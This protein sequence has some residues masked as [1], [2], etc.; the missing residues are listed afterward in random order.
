MK[1]ETLT[2]VKKN[3][4]EEISLISKAISK[5]RDEIEENPYILEAKKVLKV[6]GYRSA[7]G[8]YWNALVDDLRNKIIHRSLDLFNKEMTFNQ[9]IKNYEDFQ[10]C[11][12]D[13]DLIEGAYKIGVI[14]WE[15]RKILH[16]AREIRHI[17]DGHPRSSDPSPIKVLDM[18]NDCNKYVLSQEFPPK[19]I[20]IDSYITTMDSKDYDNN[21]I[22]VE[23]A[24]SDLPAV[25]KKELINKF[26]AI[27]TDE[28]TSTILRANIE[29]CLPILWSVLPKEDRSQIGH[30]FNT[31]ITSG[32]KK[33]IK[34]GTEFLCLIN[35]LR[36]AANSARK[37]IFEPVLKR[38]EGN[39][40]QWHEEG[41]TVRELER[42]GSNI[43][44]ELIHRYVSAL[45]LTYVGYKGL[46]IQCARTDFYSNSAAPVI[47]KL[48]DKL[49]NRA[50]QEFFNNIKNN[51][52]LKSRIINSGQL[53]RLRNLA[54]IILDRPGLQKDVQE[55]LE[56]LVDESKTD[57]FLGELFFEPL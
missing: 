5:V 50:A 56:F 51:K 27:Y 34:R 32:N 12:T 46:S 52:K 30:R 6:E 29:F 7:I 45:T 44:D 4:A 19:I 25:Y 43:P 41:E 28:N 47:M 38:L 15:A 11:V 42:L 16:H 17:F 24:F 9:T 57:D 26:Y 31:D 39:L 8:S 33:I 36:Y 20:D 55:F 53:A 54:N 13:N 1:K 49:D 14:D 21:E 40:D 10:K 18:I 23:Q 22:A 37:A 48:F 2:I 35:G 3:S